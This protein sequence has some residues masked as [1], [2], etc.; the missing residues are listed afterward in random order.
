MHRF[1]VLRHEPGSASDREL[2][3]DLMLED[4]SCLRTWS[5]DSEPRAGSS[6]AAIELPDHRKDYLDYEGPVSN[7]RGF[8]TRFDRGTYSVIRESSSELVIEIE[9]EHLRTAVTLQSRGADQRWLVAF[10][11]G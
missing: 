10:D 9:G 5:L 4:E 1:V 7:E 6:I 8:V 2:H 11:G 3:W